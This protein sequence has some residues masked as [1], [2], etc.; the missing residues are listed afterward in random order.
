MFKC[1]KLLGASLAVV[2]GCFQLVPQMYSQS[3]H[4]S[5]MKKW[6]KPT[7][8]Y[9]G[10]LTND[11]IQSTRDLFDIEDTNNVYET[12]VDANDLYN[13]LGICWQRYI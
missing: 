11:Q 10:G 6:G 1:N 8:V 4:L 9:G 2:M 13:Y 12:S 3:I 5:L 7:V